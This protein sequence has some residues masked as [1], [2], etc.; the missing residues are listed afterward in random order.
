MKNKIERLQKII[1][2][3][4]LVSRHKAE[5]LIKEKKVQVNGIIAS[6][7][8]KASFNDEI[9]V[10][11]Q[12][13]NKIEKKYFLMNK[14]EK[15]ICSL[16]DPQNRQIITD[17]MNE[18]TTIFPIGRLDYNTTG[19]ILLTN[20]GELS[21]RLSHPKFMI[22]RV[23][24]ARLDKAL[25]KDQLLFLNSDK[26]IINDKPSK[27]VVKQVDNK[28]YII[29]LKQGSYHHVKKLFEIFS[30]FVRSL[31]R[32]EFAGLSHIGLKKGE[33]RKLT[34]KEIRYLKKLVNLI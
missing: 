16:K 21:Q 15:T 20:D 6:I 32:I 17:L 2:Q 12:I 10:N 28:S 24:R 30:C 23:Y 11:G 31:N 22:K 8:T 9:I 19:T 18:K 5:I 4:G 13:I 34:I 14:P 33:Y 3:S 1:A 7:G 29:E 27:Q 26:V 25:T